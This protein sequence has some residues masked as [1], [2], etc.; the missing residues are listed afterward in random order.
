MNKFLGKIQKACIMLKILF[1]EYFSTCVVVRMSLSD[2]YDGTIMKSNWGDDINFWFLREIIDGNLINYDWSIRTK[3]FKKPFVSGIGSILTLFNMD[4]AI[5]WGS[6]IISSKDKV[7]GCPKDVRA[8][9]GPLT[10]QR[11]I[12]Q[13]IECPEVYG[14]P[15]LL[16]P[17]YYTPDAKKKYKIGVIPHYVDQNNPLF[18]I[19]RKEENVLFIDI[20]K[21]NHWL[22]FVDQICQCNVIASSSLHGLIISEAYGIPNVWIK[23]EGSELCDDFKFHDFFLS[24]E[25]DRNPV[26]IN[27]KVTSVELMKESEE[28][29]KSSIDLT[30]LIKACPFKLKQ[31]CKITH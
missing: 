14:D 4:N 21:Y 28:W 30:K 16:L 10:R 23:L 24:L 25:R 11:L 19:L 3:L 6:G 5:V 7:I 31:N 9:R 22:D 17:H 13:G 12:E 2:H 20:R 1:K 27:K 15:A 8:V 18:D 26:I 29:K